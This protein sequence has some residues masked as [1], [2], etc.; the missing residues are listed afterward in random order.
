ME[1]GKDYLID[2]GLDKKLSLQKVAH[3]TNGVDLEEFN[4]NAEVYNNTNDKF[5]K[6]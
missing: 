6:K 2:K 3:I 1:G 5:D 4:K